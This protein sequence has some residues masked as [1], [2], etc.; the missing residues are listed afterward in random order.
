MPSRKLEVEIV[1]DASSLQR[2]LGSAGKSTS[3]LSRGF[4]SLAKAGVL[5]GAALGG[6][7][8]IGIKRSIDAASDLT[9]QVNKANVVF[10]GSQEQVLKWSKGLETSFGLSQRAALEAAGTFGNMLVP[11]G[12]ARK[13]AA[14]MSEQMVELAGDMASFNN[15]SPEETLLAIRAGLAGETEPLR[16][17]GVFLSAARVEQE[18][19]IETGKKSTK[20]LTEQEKATARYNLILKD[21]ADT[22]GDFARSAGGS[23]ANQVRIL[24]AQFEDLAASLGQVFLPIALGV[25]KFLNQRLVPALTAVA[26]GVGDFIDKLRTGLSR[27]PTFSARLNVVFSNVQELAGKFVGGVIDAVERLLP[28]KPI[29]FNPRLEARGIA[30]GGGGVDW[31]AVA[32]DVV[33]A[34]SFA[35]Q[36]STDMAKAIAETIN[37]AFAQIDWNAAGKQIAPGF[38]TMVGTAIATALDPAF[39]IKNWELALSLA[40]VA[41][42]V[43]IFEFAGKAA[44]AM[45]PAMLGVLSRISPSFAAAFG[46]LIDDAG[47]VALAAFRDVERRLFSLAQQVFG[48]LT[49]VAV[50]TIKVLGVAAAINAIQDFARA[51]IQKLKEFLDWLSRLPA[52]VA[53]DAAAIGRAIADGI[54]SGIGDLG[55]RLLSKI[56]GA[57]DWAKSQVK[58]F[59][60][61]GSPSR[62]AADEIGVPLGEGIVVGVGEG[63]VKLPEKMRDKIQDALDAAKDAIT[64]AQ[65]TFASAFDALASAALSAFDKVSSEF[66]TRTERKIRQQDERRASQER[67]RALAEANAAV[68]KARQEVAG[69]TQKEDESPEDFATRIREAQA[70]VTAALQQQADAEFAIRRAADEKKAAQERQQ[71]EASRERQRVAFERQL[72]TLQNQLERGRI[73]AQQFRQRVLE[74]FEKFDIPFRNAG[75]LLG[76]SLSAGLYDSFQD[77]AKAARNLIETIA[78]E[79][80]KVRFVVSVSVQGGQGVERR[81]HGGPVTRGTPYL[82]GEKGPEL[83]VPNISGGIVPQLAGGGGAMAEIHSHL[84]LDGK[85]FTEVVRR[86]M[87]RFEKRNGTSAV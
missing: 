7:A 38:V 85:Q 63:M 41:F 80:R 44:A 11:M 45:G 79:L 15:A 40:A 34:F 84:Y 57:W 43:K 75:R 26:G 17:F 28:Q 86:E 64:N 56:K 76:A 24:K 83:F 32:A 59:L 54:I 87:L 62:V 14:A 35:L 66:E 82:V 49:R 53:A 29:V 69:L 58:G 77:A 68:R 46:R 74:L 1:G 6:A 4:A 20:Q 31:D 5:V 16:R 39:W 30:S 51:A 55:S 47:R 22:Q 65:G 42:R 27:A 3:T 71:Y 25:L 10:R 21:T 2:A 23:V 60:H 9:E 37:N 52:T 61:I 18:A 72:E 70:A 67:N 73:S 13:E 12:F 78:E 33:A 50:F 36:K 8:A 81:Q 19:L 48:R